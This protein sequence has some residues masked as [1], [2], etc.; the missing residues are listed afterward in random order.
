MRGSALVSS[1][2]RMRELPLLIRLAVFFLQMLGSI[3]P[4][5]LDNLGLKSAGTVKCAFDGGF[6][7]LW[8]GTESNAQLYPRW[9]KTLELPLQSRIFDSFARKRGNKG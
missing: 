2:F 3:W 8:V 1:I 4:T 6:A 7:G 9:L 5:R